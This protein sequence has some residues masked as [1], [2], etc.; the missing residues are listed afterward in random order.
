MHTTLKFFFLFSLA[1]FSCRHQSNDINYVEKTL[2]NEQA[3]ISMEINGKDFYT[4]N[5]TFDV[6]G[7]IDKQGLKLSFKNSKMGNVIFALD[8]PNFTQE[9]PL[10]INFSGGASQIG[11]VSFLIG[12]MDE[13]IQD[14]GEGY[15]F[16]E[17]EIILKEVNKERLWAEVSGKVKSPFST[18]D[19]TYPIKGWFLWKK[20]KWSKQ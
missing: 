20:P 11:D 9:L 18:N 10:K 7:S 17:G 4:T 8:K 14:K 12:K 6:G 5:S 15:V 2:K 13:K 1:F 19:A 3:F 16:Y